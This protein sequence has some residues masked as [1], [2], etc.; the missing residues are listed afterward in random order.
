MVERKTIVSLVAKEAFR[1]IVNDRTARNAS[2][3]AKNALATRQH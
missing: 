2:T 1:A 3:L